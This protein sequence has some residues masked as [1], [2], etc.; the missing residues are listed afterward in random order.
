ML[1]PPVLPTVTGAGLPPATTRAGMEYY[2]SDA[3]SNTRGATA[4]GGGSNFVKV[5]SNGT[6]WI[7]A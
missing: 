5:Y 1:K 2:M 4:V 3:N 7:I 6:N